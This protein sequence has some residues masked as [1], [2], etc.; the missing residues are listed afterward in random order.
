MNTVL[1]I[2]AVYYYHILSLFFKGCGLNHT[3]P[4]ILDFISL[5]VE[6]YLEENV[7][8]ERN[9]LKNLNDTLSIQCFLWISKSFQEMI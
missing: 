8:H 7:Y 2:N 1:N 5:F 3:S 4:A 9:L 6:K